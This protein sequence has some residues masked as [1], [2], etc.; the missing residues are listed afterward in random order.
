MGEAVRL[1]PGPGQPPEAVA[2]DQ[3]DR[4]LMSMTEL[5]YQRGYPQ[6]AVR[7]LVRRAGVSKTTFYRLFNGK[8][9][10][11]LEAY[12]RASDTLT[13]VMF[14]A[15][16][17]CV[18]I[19]QLFECGIRTFFGWV[20][21]DPPSAH[22]L[23]L[24]PLSAEKEALGRMRETESRLGDLLAS[25][26][27]LLDRGHPLPTYLPHA[28]VGGLGRVARLQAGDTRTLVDVE[29]E[30]IRWV[31]ALTDHRILE[32]YP[33]LASDELNGRMGNV[34]R[35]RRGHEL[36][37]DGDRA[38]I[39]NSA[40]RIAAD[41]GFSG[42]TAESVAA[43]AG[44]PRRRVES[45]FSDVADY[46]NKALELGAASI[47]A[48]AR[49][50]YRKGPPGPEGV[51]RAI[52]AIC[53]FFAAEPDIARLVFVEVFGPGRGVT[54]SGANMLSAVAGLMQRRGFAGV[55]QSEVCAEASLGAAWALMRREVEQARTGSLP[56]L[57]PVLIWLVLAPVIGAPDA[58]RLAVRGGRAG[59]DPEPQ[60]PG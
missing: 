27:E 48:D 29:E 52:R 37:V 46:F 20:R 40:L 16:E 34:P 45:Q 5:A 50:A 14:A 36:T 44:I 11:F 24:E 54:K 28:I 30:S 2:A 19:A 53:E 56:L 7:E 13:D 6:V 47:V 59:N 35:R 3:S 49:S 51:A 25:R 22:L 23:L 10:C 9:A 12:D 32:I 57:A 15:T 60:G 31:K 26:F 43:T 39:I 4:L 18:D 8:E 1:R 21:S 38:A 41:Q 33:A 17:D 42:L 58:V 55:A